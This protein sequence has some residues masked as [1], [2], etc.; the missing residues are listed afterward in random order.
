MARGRAQL[1]Q[2]APR[3]ARAHAARGLRDGAADDDETTTW[4]SARKQLDH[5]LEKTP[6]LE[7]V[8]VAIFGGVV[9]PDK[10][11]F[12]FS[13]MPASDA[14]DWDAIRAWADEVAETV[15]DEVQFPLDR[16]APV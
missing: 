9:D 10:L 7:P 15:G 11:R 14:R 3:R 1:P 4:Q 13:H 6:E 8:A 5:A 12:P 2:G 16:R